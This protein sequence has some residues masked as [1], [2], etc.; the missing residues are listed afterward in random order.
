MKD[1]PIIEVEA[2][3][4]SYGAR[5]ALQE[6]SFSV[7][8]GEIFGLLG[9][10][11]GGK[12]TLFQALATLIVPSGGRAR[13]FGKDVTQEAA[14]IRKRIGV[15]FQSQSLD[16]KLTVLENLSHQGHLYGLHGKSLRER[17]REVLARIG[18]SDR[19][20]ELVEHLSDG[21]RRR[22][23][24]AK[25]LLHRPELLLL[26]E[27]STGLD[28]V[29]RR[30]LW[31]QLEALRQKDGV[32]ILLTTHLMDEAENCDRL[33]ILDRGRLVALDSPG[34]LKARIGGDVVS[35][36]SKDPER[37]REQIQERFG[38]NPI[39]VDGTVRIER[40]RGHEFIAQLI[41]AFPGQIEAITLG[42]PTLEDVFIHETGH[43]FAE[44]NGTREGD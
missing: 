10:N 15:V 21:L 26:D 14:E 16:R 22:V 1:K 27:P 4:H 18:L 7:R 3:S 34:A 5:Q 6:V 2:L 32:T 42:K 39:I 11:G 25:G 8:R 9:P 31:Q 33:G 35:A 44:D 24:L 43:R 28:P 29:A 23:E 36:R 20:D 37:L 41:E 19:R 30:E 13:V 17:S 38:G 40:P 12:T